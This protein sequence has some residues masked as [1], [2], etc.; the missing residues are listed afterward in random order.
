MSSIEEDSAENDFVLLEKNIEPENELFQTADLE[1]PLTELE[2][3]LVNGVTMS[4]CLAPTDMKARLQTVPTII[5]TF[6]KNFTKLKSEAKNDSDRIQNEIFELYNS[7]FTLVKS[8]LE[9]IEQTEPV[10][11][12][13][14]KVLQEL[15]D[16]QSSRLSKALIDQLFTNGRSFKSAFDNLKP[17][18]AELTKNNLE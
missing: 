3:W 8:I 5:E 11:K 16:D 7:F 1:Q 10:L 4:V 2:T 9:L 12:S 18:E 15:A 13:S 14:E 6:H 17:T